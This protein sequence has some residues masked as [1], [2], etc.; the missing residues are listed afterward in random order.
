M[1]PAEGAATDRLA[2]GQAVPGGP[3]ACTC[4]HAKVWHTPKTSTRPCEVNGCSCTTWT[5]P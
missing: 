3:G 4:H 1:T 5:Q 2:H